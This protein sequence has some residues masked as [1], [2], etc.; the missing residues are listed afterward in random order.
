MST[1]GHPIVCP[2]CKLVNWPEHMDGTPRMEC[3]KCS[4]SFARMEAYRRSQAK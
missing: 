3:F 2:M 1:V 4:Y